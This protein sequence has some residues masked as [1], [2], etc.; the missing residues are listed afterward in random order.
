MWCRGIRGATTVPANARE[1]ILAA[2]KELLQKIIDANQVDPKAVGVIFFTT[3]PDLNAE[4]PAAA[5]RSM[6]WNETPLLCAQEIDVPHSLSQCL[7]ILI[8]VN[9]EKQADEIVHIYLHGAEALRKEETDDC[10]N[11]KGV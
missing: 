2:T 9:T 8:L 10:S 6:G 3:T 11:E 1:A 4:F 7:R 5:A